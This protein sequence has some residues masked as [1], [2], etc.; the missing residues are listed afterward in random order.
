M[1]IQYNS[2]S[3]SIYF[4]SQFTPQAQEY[5]DKRLNECTEYKRNKDTREYYKMNKA[6][7]D[8]YLQFARDTI[9]QIKA[10]NPTKYSVI[11]LN[12][13]GDRFICNTFKSAEDMQKGDWNGSMVVSNSLKAD[14]NID[15]DFLKILLDLKDGMVKCA[16]HYDKLRYD[17]M[18][19]LFSSYSTRSCGCEGGNCNM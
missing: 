6:Y 19:R 1:R 14:F 13:K 4:K 16:D 7:Y 5:I 12:Y 2:I 11:D 18:N 10:I 9:K 8:E 17:Y 15:R 3:P